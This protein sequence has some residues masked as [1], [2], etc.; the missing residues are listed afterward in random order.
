MQIAKRMKR[1]SPSPTLAIDS[2]AKQLKASGMD[3]INFGAGEPDFDTP[4][5]IKKAGI[6]AIQAGYTKYTPASGSMELK[7]AV[8]EKLSRENGLDYSVKQVVI[9]CGAKHSIYNICQAVLDPGD[10][11]IIP[12]PYWVSYPEAVKLA[13][14]KPV[15]MKTTEKNGFKITAA[16]LRR[17]IKPKTKMLILNSPSNPT[18]AVYNE[19]ELKDIMRVAIVK[20]IIVLSDEI[21]EHLIYDNEKHVSPAAVLPKA[22]DWTIVVNGVSKAFSMTG[23]RIGY[24]AAPEEVIATIAKLQSHSTSNPASISMKAALAAL[25]KPMSAFGEMK[26]SFEE[27][28][29][30]V[31]GKLNAI[32]GVTCEMPQGAFYVFPNIGG[33]LGK[34]LGNKTISTSMQLA[35]HLLENAQVAVVPGDG[36][37]ADEF[38]RISYATSLDNLK[39][40]LDRIAK[41]LAGSKLK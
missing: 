5:Y 27:R 1:V 3:I 6:E 15:V 17:R 16:T 14:A 26:K 36:F 31:V 41:A 19:E 12:A 39:K 2:K 13:G 40:G 30:F 7:E 20:K 18:G 29:E 21:Y 25:T 24:I 37:G 9:N 8:C 38:L 22:K 28:R 10:E 32:P 35:D 23:W 33:L 4:D 34:K 11:V